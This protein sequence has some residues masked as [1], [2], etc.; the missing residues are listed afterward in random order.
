MGASASFSAKISVRSPFF[1][2]SLSNFLFLDQSILKVVSLILKKEA[3]VG[4]T[5]AECV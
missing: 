2:F 5:P 3:L 1:L 4:A